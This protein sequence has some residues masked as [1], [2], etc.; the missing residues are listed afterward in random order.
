MRSA[1]SLLLA[2]GAPAPTEPLAI[3]AHG[4]SWFDY[5]LSGNDLSL[6]NTDIIAQLS[7][8]G[9]VP[10]MILNIAHFGDATTKE[11]SL[12]K[13]DRIVRALQDPSNWLPRGKPD[14]ILFSGGGDDIA[15]SQFC[16]FLDYNMG[17]GGG[18]DPARFQDALDGVKASYIDLFVFRDRYA[19]RL[20]I[21][22]PSSCPLRRTLRRG[23]TTTLRAA[24]FS[25]RQSG[26]F[27]RRLIAIG[28]RQLLFRG[29]EVV[30]VGKQRKVLELGARRLAHPI[31]GV[32]TR[33]EANHCAV[34]PCA[35]GDRLLAD[36]PDRLR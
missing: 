27:F 22:Q 23:P 29:S 20:R 5:P 11:M 4:D 28:G 21:G 3:L 26:N 2:A 24:R 17:T 33:P 6:G 35:V 25:R 31:R 36:S 19:T 34:I 1:T 15:G 7:V 18:L 10:P 9:N 32:G 12:P 8:L 30:V 14:A 13:R 16:I